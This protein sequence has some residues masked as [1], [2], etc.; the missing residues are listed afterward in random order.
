MNNKEIDLDGQVKKYVEYWAKAKEEE[1]EWRNT[2]KKKFD[3]FDIEDSVKM[4]FSLRTEDGKDRVYLG[5]N[6]VEFSENGN[7]VIK[8]IVRSKKIEDLSFILVIEVTDICGRDK[9]QYG[10][11]NSLV[12]G[13]TFEYNISFHN[14]ER[15]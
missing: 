13:K 11:E 12:V 10:V 1:N 14:I 6:E 7:C 5:S 15:I 3:T 2:A 4:N 9:V 8:G